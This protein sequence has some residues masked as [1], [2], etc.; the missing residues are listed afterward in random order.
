MQ[1][2]AGVTQ[3]PQ[4]VIHGEM[5]LT[6][7]CGCISPD[8]K[9]VLAYIRLDSKMNPNKF[10]FKLENAEETDSQIHLEA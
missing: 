7:V 3:H 4:F 9:S 8:G 5:I 10:V 6:V 1:V 2:C